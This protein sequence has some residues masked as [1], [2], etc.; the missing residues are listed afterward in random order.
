MTTIRKRLD[1]LE[2]A[3]PAAAKAPRVIRL[4]VEEDGDTP[5]AAIGRWRVENPD[6]PAP[7]DDDVIILRS[8]VS[9][10]RAAA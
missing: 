4:I 1:V 7:S 9:P 6:L 2:K 5:E 3:R 10:H 8:I